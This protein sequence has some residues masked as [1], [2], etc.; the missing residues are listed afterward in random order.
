MSD[1]A[2]A[3]Q[4]PFDS[5]RHVDP[6]DN[7]Y[8]LARELQVVL[9]YGG[10][11][12]WQNF[13]RAI[14]DAITACRGQGYDIPTLF[15]DATKKGEGRPRKDYQLA[16]F[17]CYMI[18]LS[19]D[20]TKDQVAEAKVYFAVKTREQELFALAQMLGDDPV[21]EAMNRIIFREELSEAHK[22]LFEQARASGVIT[23]EQFAVFMNWGYKGL[24]AGETKEAIQQ[25]KHLTPRQNISDYMSAL[26]AFANMLRSQIATR[27]L[28]QQGTS[29]P[30]E[31][32]LVHYDAGKE[33]RSIL[34]HAGQT[35]EQLPTPT[36]SYKQIVREAAARLDE[37][38]RQE[39]LEEE[40][41]R[42]LWGQLPEGGES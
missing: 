26:E 15:S 25:R 14:N 29:T 4:S 9:G 1:I 5:I 3:G 21:V 11:G 2:P 18:A 6:Q 13:E 36:K 42:G 34:L 40:Y 31:A 24:Y 38:E 35:P 39:A 17:A 30:G 8:W 37:E 27:N 23:S 12:G 28:Q 20:S 32:G 41:Q 16:R 33:V 10:K 19:A 7:E 22:A